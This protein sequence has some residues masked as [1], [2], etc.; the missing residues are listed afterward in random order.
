MYWKQMK[1]ESL[2]LSKAKALEAA[3][4]HASLPDTPTERSKDKARVKKLVGIIRN[5]LALPFNWA[6]IDYNGVVHRG[7]GM[8]SAAAI[9]E[10]G[11]DL[12]DGLIFH[13][14]HYKVP[15]RKGMVEL[16]RQFDQRWSSR[17]VL[18]IAGAFAGLVPEL[19]HMKGTPACKIIAEGISWF[20][21]TVE[22][23]GGTG[24]YPA[25][26][27]VF[28]ILHSDDHIPFIVWAFKTINGRKVLTRRELVAAMYGTY[29]VSQSGSDKFWSEVGFGLNF[30]KEGA[31]GGILIGELEKAHDDPDFRAK[32]FPQS[33]FYYRKAI[34]AWN[35]FCAG[36]RISTLRVAKK[37]WPDI[38][39]P[40]A[41]EEDGEGAAA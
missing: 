25:G 1:S 36:E 26:D 20:G 6:T 9:M 13:I 2:T 24:K 33:A 28:D 41:S 21:N 7:N 11:S 14:D 3:R 17:S 40:K 39:H 32:E 23:S 10:V 18:D 4:K 37:G 19:V 38:D 16:F 12:P 27:H 29:N 34:K 31:P 5:G 22:G 15:D 35:A 30:F 8:H